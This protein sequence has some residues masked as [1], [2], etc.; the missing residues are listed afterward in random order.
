MCISASPRKRGF[1]DANLVHLSLWDGPL[2]RECV[3]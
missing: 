1:I 3:I 2:P